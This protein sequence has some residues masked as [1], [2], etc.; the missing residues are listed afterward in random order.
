LTPELLP[1]REVHARG[2]RW[3]IVFSQ[4]LGPETLFRLRGLEGAMKGQEFDFLHPFETLNPIKKGP[5][6]LGGMGGKAIYKW[7]GE[8]GDTYGFTPPVLHS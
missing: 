4:K 5:Q 7:R 1:G 3:E 2:L 6:A 8:P